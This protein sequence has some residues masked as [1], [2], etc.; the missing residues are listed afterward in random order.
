MFSCALIL[1]DFVTVNTEAL[2]SPMLRSRT[3]EPVS[4]KKKF[5][6]LGIEP[7]HSMLRSG[8]CTHQAIVNAR[9]YVGQMVEDS[10]QQQ[11][12]MCSSALMLADFVTRDL[13]GSP[14]RS[15]QQDNS[16]SQTYILRS[17]LTSP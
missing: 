7:T 6:A 12:K 13:R 16:I 9:D 3:F 17:R 15:N 8:R 5:I 2:P 1:A 11:Q 4:H 14:R 10:N